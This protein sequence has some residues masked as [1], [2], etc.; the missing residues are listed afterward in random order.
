MNLS[1][2]R[3]LIVV[4][5]IVIIAMASYIGLDAYSGFMISTTSSSYMAGYNDGVTDTVRQ[6]VAQS[7]S[8]NPMPVF[9]GNVTRNLIDI[10]CLQLAQPQP[11]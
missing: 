11:G 4:L 2:S 7:A 3:L 9:F 6:I 1:S 8:C 5:L 10:S